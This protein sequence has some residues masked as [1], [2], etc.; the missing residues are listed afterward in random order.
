MYRPPLKVGIFIDEERD[1]A[2]V[3]GRDIK[4][5][6]QGKGRDSTQK[7]MVIYVIWEGVFYVYVLMGTD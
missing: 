5:V 1:Q 2:Y 7:S 4:E 6:F 3:P